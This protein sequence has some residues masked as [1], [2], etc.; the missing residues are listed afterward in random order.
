M[1]LAAV[2]ETPNPVPIARYAAM[3]AGHF[4]IIAR[5]VPGTIH[6]AISRYRRV[7]VATPAGGS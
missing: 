7:E 1:L 3:H 6:P 2:I 5:S 4:G